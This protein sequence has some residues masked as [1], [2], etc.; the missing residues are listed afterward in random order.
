MKVWVQAELYCESSQ[1]GFLATIRNAADNL[2]VQRSLN[3]PAWIG[4]RYRDG[5]WWWSEGGT[6]PTNESSDA[7]TDWAYSNWAPGE[8]SMHGCMQMRTNGLWYAAAC[9]VI[10][11]E[12]QYFVC[13]GI[14]PPPSPPPPSPPPPSPPPSPPPPSP[15]PPSPPP[16][17]PPPPS[18]PPLPPPPA[19]PVIHVLDPGNANNLNRIWSDP[20]VDGNILTIA[21]GP[22]QYNLSV[23][24]HFDASTRASEVRFSG[25]GSTVLRAPD[26]SNLLS[27]LPGAPPVSMQGLRLEGRIA[28][29]ASQ[30]QI[31]SCEL[32]RPDAARSRLRRHL[33][34]TSFEQGSGDSGL[35]D[36]SSSG[37][38]V[39]ASNGGAISITGGVVEVRNATLSGHVTDGNGGA[40]H[41]DGGIAR[42]DNCIFEL[43]EAE[44]DGGALY[45]RSGSVVLG[46]RTQLRANSAAGRGRSIFVVAGTVTYKLPAP[47]GRWVDFGSCRRESAGRALS[48]G[49]DAAPDDDGT[50][51]VIPGATDLDY[52]FA[53]APGLYGGSFEISQQSSAQ[54][55]GQCP[56]GRFCPIATA[57]PILC[58]KGRYCPGSDLTGTLGAT[59]ALACP[60]GYFSDAVDLSS[61]DGCRATQPGYYA[62]TGSAEQTIC[63]PGTFAAIGGLGSCNLCQR[64]KF[65][66][67]SGATTCEDCVAGNVCA[68]GSSAPQPCPA[69]SYSSATNLSHSDHCTACVAGSACAV[70][71][72]APSICLPGS[73]APNASAAFCN[74][75]VP[76]TF[77]RAYGRR[78]CIPCVAGFYCR[79]GAA[80]PVPCPGGYVGNATGLYSAGQCTPVPIGF[81]APLGS[82]LPEPCPASG[83]Y[84]PGAL[85][86][87]LHGGARPIIMPVGHSTE[88]HLV[89]SLVQHLLIDISIDDF[90]TQREA[91]TRQFATQYDVDPSLIT[92]QTSAG[93]LLI[94]LT[95][96]TT[97]GTSAPLSLAT[98]EQRINAVD[99]AALAT[100]I[101]QVMGTNITVTSAP[102]QRSVVALIRL[103]YHCPRGMWVRDW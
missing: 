41:V 44:G 13:H 21:F 10:G 56:S 15:P 73:A 4:G 61:V 87:I 59:A 30:L 27:M 88:T 92:L 79:E 11:T 67:A 74:L 60:A 35:E 5:W 57:D 53:C 36:S 68:E 52:P 69:G 66:G 54:C 84:C 20:N 96:A 49:I 29:A 51:L 86:D 100:S 91:L 39:D 26:G 8:P 6:F 63:A 50:A 17:S 9:D 19:P 103:P 34:S 46:A 90:A 16:P 31:D 22:L 24:M 64:G 14:A 71:S 93:S 18:P 43:N 80:E 75:C 45:V 70:G 89:D 55:S 72:T 40:V 62:P 32:C 28:V 2:E 37:S 76:G 47:L 82:D 81:W 42:F 3:G 23:S 38:L 94:V 98:L 65:V 7:A 102:L 33:Q 95:V 25:N 58:G 77:Q 1:D 101:G 48:I 85:R 99:D 78:A 83:F 12:L 97:N